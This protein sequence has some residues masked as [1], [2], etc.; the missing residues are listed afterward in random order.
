MIPAQI[1]SDITTFKNLIM[2]MCELG[3]A[4]HQK[5]VAPASDLMSEREAFRRFGE[6]NV[7]C[8]IKDSLANF[9]RNGSASNSKKFY[10]YSELLAIE[11]SKKILTK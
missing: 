9:R 6:V 4:N 7:K 3:V 5:N 1:A 11:K 10:S 8:W 2:E